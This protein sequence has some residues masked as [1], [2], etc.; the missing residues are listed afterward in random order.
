MEQPKR[1]FLRTAALRKYIPFAVLG[2][3]TVLLMVFF[4]ERNEGIS[5]IFEEG[6][7]NVLSFYA[8]NLKPLIFQTTIS[9]E[10]IFNFALFNSLPLDKDKNKILE[11]SHDQTGRETFVIR[12]APYNRDTKNYDT[13]VKYIGMNRDQ[14]QKIDSILNSYK[15]DIYSSVL[16]NEK[17]TYA[18]NPN[19]TDLQQAVLADIISYTQSID[20][21]KSNE[22]FAEYFSTRDE[23]RLAGLIGSAKKISKDEYL[24][25]T[26]DTVARTYFKWDQKNF[27]KNYNDLER[28]K[29]NMLP[30]PPEFKIEYEHPKSWTNNVSGVHKENFSFNIDTNYM[31]VVI[32]VEGFNLSAAVQESL[33]VKLGEAAKKL[34]SIRFK[35]EKMS[36]N[37]K[38]KQAASTGEPEEII[39]PFELANQALQ[40]F[41]GGKEWSN[42]GG[43]I[44]SLSRLITPSM[45]DS[46][47]NEI[48]REIRR[49]ANEIK[50]AKLKERSDSLRLKK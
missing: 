41:S 50:N 44:D 16:L 31:K 49:A 10:D 3:L 15:K 4:K 1:K 2:I 8:E 39:N 7:T 34:K 29:I 43:K 17:N 12:T 23:S 18:V 13:F 24:L 42:L 5:K 22:K 21:N 33:R 28:K 20:K 26:P 35:M 38:R 47:K 30:P 27:D 48:R 19:I 6:K 45:K 11:I 40:F 9:Q 32:P 25:I 37:M 46:I 36:G 14:K